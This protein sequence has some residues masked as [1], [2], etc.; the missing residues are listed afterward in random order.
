MQ[1][2]S[3]RDG[4]LGSLIL[5][6]ISFVGAGCAFAIICVGDFLASGSNVWNVTR[7]EPFAALAASCLA[8]VW[9]YGRYSRYKREIKAAEAFSYGMDEE[10]QGVWPP[11][12]RRPD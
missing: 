4:D 6:T 1:R 2:L 11:S 5:F 8:L 7:L 9:R 3:P 12:P 10:Q